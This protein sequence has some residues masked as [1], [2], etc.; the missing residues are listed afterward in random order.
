MNQRT[1]YQLTMLRNWQ[2]A[3]AMLLF[4]L[5]GFLAPCQAQQ[6]VG[7][8]TG[9]VFDSSGAA[10]GNAAVKA[11][12]VATNL[13]VAVHSESN[14]TYSIS[15]LPA[16]T[17]EL[18]FTKEGFETETHTQVLVQEGRTATVDGSLKVGSVST[19]VE[20]TA[21]PLMNQTDATN[22][23]VVDQLT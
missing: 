16:G 7:A 11:H 5:T 15:N 9:T 19:T 22:G 10:V 20:V 3:A 8:I 18:T 13:D 4:V 17:Y 21:T 6:I 12:N 14:G 23:Y 1:N 2:A